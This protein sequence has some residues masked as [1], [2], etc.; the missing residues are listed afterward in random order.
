MGNRVMWWVVA[1]IFGGVLTAGTGGPGVV[2]L[3]FVFLIGILN[4]WDRGRGRRER[5]TRW[6]AEHTNETAVSPRLKEPAG[7]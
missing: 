4:E 5:E 2:F 7:R 3:I 1:L 6:K